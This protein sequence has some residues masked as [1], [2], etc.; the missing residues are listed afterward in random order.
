MNPLIA[1]WMLVAY[2]LLS[3]EIFLATYALARFEMSYLYFGPT[4]L[5]ILLCAGNL[6]VFFHPVVHPFGLPLGLWDFGAVLG[7]IG[8][9]VIAIVSFVRHTH[10]LYDAERLQ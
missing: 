3:A 7:S 5:R 9:T 6:Y 1:V 4:E 2:L 8:M 10:V